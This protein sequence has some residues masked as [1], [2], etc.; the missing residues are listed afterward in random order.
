MSKKLVAYFSAS[1][2]TKKVALRLA[3][4]E[5]AELFEICPKIEYTSADLNWM[6]DNSRSSLEMKAQS[7]RPEILNKL[8][9]LDQYEIIYLGF[10]I[11]WYVE[12]RIIDTF[13][14][15][16]NFSKKQIVPFA[17]SGGSGISNVVENLKAH[18]PELNFA[19][20][21]LLNNYID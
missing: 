11:W 4:E 5:L 6:D 15:S 14:E 16:Y 13:L 12:P 10:P 1:G 20:G 18:Y 17:T 19:D 7:C 3:Q 21:R 8:D 2:V 9:N